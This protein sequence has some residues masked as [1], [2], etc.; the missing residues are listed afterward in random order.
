MERGEATKRLIAIVERAAAGGELCELVEEIHVFGSYARGA[1]QPR[2]LDLSVSYKLTAAESRKWVEALLGGCDRTL[3]L[4]RALRGAW[5]SVE[6]QFNNVDDLRRAGFD[7]T[8]VW[9]HGEPVDTARE[10]LAGFREDTKAGT[11]PRDPVIAPLVGLGRYVARPHREQLA[12]L[13]HLALIRIERLELDHSAPNGRLARLRIQARWSETNPKIRAVRTAAA[14]LERQGYEPN[15]ARNNLCSD[16][17]NPDEHGRQ[18][19]KAVCYFGGG[20]IGEATGMLGSGSDEAL[21]VLNPSSRNAVLIG[22]RFM[23]LTSQVELEAHIY[24]IEY[25]GDGRRKLL[26]RLLRENSEKS[27]PDTLHA[28]LAG[29]LR[30]EDLR[31]ERRNRQF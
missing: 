1:L 5:R 25:G 12:L 2:D 11:A 15:F 26:E 10:R 14:W 9:R 22:L 6:I 21:V 4:R 16:Q 27:L 3:D 20:W 28:F 19:A 31:N 8:L 30:A 7:P 29:L 24:A 13:D 18:V 17:T 23:R